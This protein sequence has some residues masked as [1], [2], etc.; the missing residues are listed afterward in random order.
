MSN[1][2]ED[3][4][5]DCIEQTRLGKALEDVLRECPE[6]AEQIRPLL[7]IA[8]E[9]E[10]LP[11]PSPSVTGI[12][13]TMAKLSLQETRPQPKRRKIVFFSRSFLIRA[14]AVLL[15]VMLGGWTT[16]TASSQALPGDLLYPI[17]LFTERA[18]FFL[19]INQEEKV[20]LRIVFSAE[21]LKEAVKKYERGQKLDRKLLQEM[22]K[23]ARLSVET[24]VDLPESTRSLLVA[25]AAYL[26]EFQK[27]TLGRFKNR[28]KPEE[29]EVLTPYMNMC[30]RRAAWMRQMVDEDSGT[31]EPQTPRNRMRRWRDMCPMWRE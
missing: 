7:A 11:E 25:R 17:K 29:Q 2:L 23:E 18:K 13:R 9:L 26:S 22:L 8:N 10:Q 12:M 16:V 24:S 14:A 5:D 20:E 21:R 1:K 4:L 6:A 3:I 19:T 28:V 30:G 27:E 15:V 31:A